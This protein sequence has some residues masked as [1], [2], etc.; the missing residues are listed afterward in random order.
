MTAKADGS[1]LKQET[2]IGR[3]LAAEVYSWGEGRV[4]K[5]YPSGRERVEVERECLITRAVRAAGF[6]APTAYEMVEVEG[7]PGIVFERL[8][9][10]SMLKQVEARPWTLFAAARQLGELHAQ[11]HQ[12]PAPREMP[13]QRRQLENGIDAAKDFSEAE[14]QIARRALAQLPD[15]DMLCHGDFHPENILLTA[16][17]PMVIDW[18]TATRG[19]P[20]ADV[21]FTSLLFRKANL[22]VTSPWQVRILFK[23]SRSLLHSAYLK[24]YFRLRPGTT[25]QLEAWLPVLAVAVAA[26]R[27]KGVS[28]L[29][30]A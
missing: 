24:R 9:G 2:L 8:H 28:Q 19:H 1:R 10:I 7:R 16:R 5:L 26:W 20:L 6:P 12:C 14:K 15:G 29:K 25:E 18:P 30:P 3:G 23:I 17:G 27:I 11:L 13:S 22:P 21:G 4:L